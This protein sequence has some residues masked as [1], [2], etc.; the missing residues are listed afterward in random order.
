[1]ATSFL[2]TRHRYT[3]LT[4]P[5]LIVVMATACGGVDAEKATAGK[6]SG[7]AGGKTLTT[8]WGPSNGQ[9]YLY[10]AQSMA[11]LEKA[12][13]LDITVR[14]S[15][16]SEENA[17]R[18][19]RGELDVG[20]LDANGATKAL[21]EGHSLTALFP[22]SIV[23]W[24]MVVGEDTDIHTIEDLAG[25]KFNAGPVGGASA[26]VTQE[27]LE[28]G[29]G[30]DINWFEATAPDAQSAY[31]GRQID[32]F[33]LR[34]AGVQADGAVLEVNSARPVRL[35]SF[36]DEQMQVAQKVS[37]DLAPAT[38]PASTYGTDKDIQALGY[39]GVVVGAAADFDEE[40][41]YLLT[42]GFWEEIDKIAAQLPQTKGM[43]P[44][45]A[46]TE[47]LMP[48][49]SGAVRYYEEL[50]IEVPSEVRA[51]AARN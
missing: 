30:L 41:A 33:A 40:Q 9:W 35:L 42:K 38:I 50:G 11:I 29:L 7:S 16:G 22:L 25:S 23:V 27:V 26:M 21:G 47:A 12:T 15:A 17:I 31:Q 45:D 20:M 2:R 46:V 14:E 28:E 51:P 32:G 3:R 19:D 34:G 39:W 48:L 8:G 4:L 1:M 18:M 24:Q 37:P 49:H 44:E 43:K 13:G 6:G 10:G 36:T 5:L